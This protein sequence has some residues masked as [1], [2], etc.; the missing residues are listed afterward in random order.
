MIQFIVLEE[1]IIPKAQKKRAFTLNLIAEI[2]NVK[3][4]WFPM[5]IQMKELES[6]ELENSDFTAAI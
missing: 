1:L 6:R 3:S 5:S 2:I 4:V